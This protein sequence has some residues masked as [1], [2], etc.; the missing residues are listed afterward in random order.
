MSGMWHEDVYVENALDASDDA[1]VEDVSGY[2]EPERGTCSTC[3]EDI[4]RGDTDDAIWLH[5][6][7][8]YDHLPRPT[9]HRDDPCCLANFHDAD[10]HAPDC[11][12]KEK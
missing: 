1:Y 8:T 7:E 3:G 9:T 10:K 5:V 12:S 11:P 4:E 6:E 2:W